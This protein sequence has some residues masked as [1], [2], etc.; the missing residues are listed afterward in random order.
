MEMKRLQQFSFEAVY[1]RD[2]IQSVSK[3]FWRW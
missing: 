1:V 2:V 3:R